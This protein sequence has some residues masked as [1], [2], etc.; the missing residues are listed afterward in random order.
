[1][2][3]KIEG[4]NPTEEQV[5][6]PADPEKIEKLCL[7]FDEGCV[8]DNIPFGSYHRCWDYDRSTGFCPFCI[9]RKTG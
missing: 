4:F 5:P 2:D 6:V 9:E 1:M 7:D 8:G 3:I